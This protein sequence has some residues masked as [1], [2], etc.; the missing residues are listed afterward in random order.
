[1]KKIFLSVLFFTLSLASYS[2][3]FVNKYNYA[4]SSK[5]GVK[6]DW[7]SISLTVVF[8]EKETD[9]VV[10]YYANGSVKRFHQLGDVSEDKT[11]ANEGYQIITCIDD[12]DGRRVALQLFDNNTSLRILI[13]EGIYVEFHK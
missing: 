5:D 2:Q 1:M 10:F 4:I 13:S 3:T 6:G 7:K 9:D 12:E 8:N 11:K